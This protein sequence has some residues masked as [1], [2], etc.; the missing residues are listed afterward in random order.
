[1]AQPLQ[2]YL[3]TYRKSSGLT[4]KDVAYLL[5]CNGGAKVSRYERLSREPNLHTALGCQVIFDAH[6]ENI[7]PGIHAGVE[8]NITKRARLLSE[9]LLTQS[10]SPRT[11]RKL[12]ALKHIVS[13]KTGEHALSS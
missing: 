12:E 8:Q 7:F 11:K 6:I 13:A 3:R 2:S 1:M 5:G 9:R 10:Q 4:Q